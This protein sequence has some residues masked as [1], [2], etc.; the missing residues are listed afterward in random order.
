MIAQHDEAGG[1][2]AATS[3]NGDSDLETRGLCLLSLDGG[4]VRGLST[5]FILRNLVS[6]ASQS[7]HWCLAQF[8]DR[9]EESS[10]F[11]YRGQ[12]TSMS[13]SGSTV[14]HTNSTNLLDEK[15]QR[16]ASRSK[17]RTA[18]AL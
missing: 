5:L 17:P 18:E 7:F 15:T 13:V 10:R 9:D 6:C 2:G 8:Q 14:T 1:G 3:S 11:S 4:G 16:G 12:M